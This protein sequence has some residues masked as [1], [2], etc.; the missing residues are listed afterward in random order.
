M[1]WLVAWKDGEVRPLTFTLEPRVIWRRV[2]SI[3]AMN[4]NLRIEL[5]W[6]NFKRQLATSVISGKSV[7]VGEKCVISRKLEEKLCELTDPWWKMC[8]LMETWKKNCA[9]ARLS[10][11]FIGDVWRRKREWSNGRRV[12]FFILTNQILYLETNNRL[13]SL[14]H[15]GQVLKKS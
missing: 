5:G 1:V 7:S 12:G 15:R 2:V 6:V 14:R 8:D 13:Q 10:R 3:V 4:S 9:G 11:F